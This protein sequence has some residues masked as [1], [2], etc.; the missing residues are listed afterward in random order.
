MPHLLFITPHLYKHL[1]IIP[2]THIYIYH[3]IIIPYP[4]TPLYDYIPHTPIIYIP[5]HTSIQYHTP[6]YTSI[7]HTSIQYH[8]PLYTTFIYTTSHLY[9]I[10]HTS[11]HHTSIYHTPP[12]STYLYT[13]TH[14]D[15]WLTTDLP[16]FT[17]SITSHTCLLEVGSS[18]AVGSSRMRISGLPMHAMAT[19]RHLLIP[20]ERFLDLRLRASYRWL[21]CREN[22]RSWKT[23][24]SSHDIYSG[25]RTLEMW[26]PL[27]SGHFQKSQSMLL[28]SL[29]E[30]WP[31][32]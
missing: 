25:T 16:P 8:T 27:Y 4:T 12:L 22:R 10:P 21:T 15:P 3:S 26:P 11:I 31:P 18:P 9:T 32:L 5:H 24:K 19:E 14:P 30:M 28:N 1:Y 23:R 13:S 2:H 6:L 29:P 7:Y 20:L 17:A